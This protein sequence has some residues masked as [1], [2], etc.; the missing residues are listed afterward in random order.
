MSNKNNSGAQSVI[1]ES[2]RGPV[3]GYYHRPEK[4]TWMG[5]MKMSREKAEELGYSR[6]RSCY[7][8]TDADQE[9]AQ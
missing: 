8:E 2:G 6:C 3:T 7:P 9:A 1:V 5:P 4:G